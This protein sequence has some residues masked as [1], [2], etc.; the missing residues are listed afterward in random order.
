MFT[1]GPAVNDLT[2]DARCEDGSE[3]PQRTYVLEKR[4]QECGPPFIELEINSIGKQLA[5][6]SSI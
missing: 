3:K 4:P 2:L 1:K 6:K 5:L